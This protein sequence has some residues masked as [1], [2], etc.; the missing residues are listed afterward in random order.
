MI[1]DNALR[2]SRLAALKHLRDIGNIDTEVFLVASNDET[3]YHALARK[4]F[5]IALQ[6]V[7]EIV[8]REI[9]DKEMAK[10]LEDLGK[11]CS[12]ISFKDGADIWFSKTGYSPGVWAHVAETILS[13]DNQNS[14]LWNRFSSI[15][16]YDF[17]SDVRAARLYP[18]LYTDKAWQ[19]LLL[20][21]STLSKTDSGWLRDVVGQNQSRID[22]ASSSKKHALIR[23]ARSMQ[24]NSPDKITLTQWTKFASEKISEF[25]PRRSE[26][27]AL[28]VIRQLV[29]RNVSDAGSQGYTLKLI[30]PENVLIPEIWKNK[31]TVYKD[32]AG[33]TWDEWQDFVSNDNNDGVTLKN[34]ANC[35]LDYRYYPDLTKGIEIGEWE[36][37][38]FA[39]GRLLLGLLRFDHTLERI[40]NIRGN[41]LIHPLPRAQMY[42]S[43][44]VSSTTLVIVEGCLSLR[45]AETRTLINFPILFGSYV[46][47]IP[48]DVN[49][50]PP[51][52]RSRKEL[53]KAIGAAQLVLKKNQLAVAMNQPRQ[54]IPFRLVDFAIGASGEIE[55]GSDDV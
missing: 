50:G 25:D 8:R 9:P 45:G 11:K 13:M 23:A 22:A 39:I 1:S 16:A 51:L 55:V 33:T 28:E 18:E 40:S 48:N 27:T 6:S 2:S 19:Q 12:G 14:A 32:R 38:L 54:L 5:G 20:S 24:N 21:K 53:L 10:S 42:Q 49:F 43:L 47:G 7:A 26:W 34:P 46:T 52:L 17:I 44:S 3:W 41:E 31:F 4:E 37:N 36:R 15:F 35:V 30:H 29:S